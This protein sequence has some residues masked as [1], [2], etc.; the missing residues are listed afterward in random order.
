MI[1]FMD[2]KL[3]ISELLRHPSYDLKALNMKTKDICSG[4]NGDEK[5][6]FLVGGIF[7]LSY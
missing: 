6:R 5:L 3:C 1:V 4:E 2:K 7:E